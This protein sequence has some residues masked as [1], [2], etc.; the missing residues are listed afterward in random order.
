M[1]GYKRIIDT[2]SGNN[3][4]PVPTMLHSFMA[5]AEEKGLSQAQY[6]SSPKNI[7][8][9]HID[10]ALKYG[11]DG[12]L[13]DIDTCMEAGAIGIHVDLPEHEPARVTTGLSTNIDI[14][15]EAMDK[16]CLKK[17]DRIQIMLEAINNISN[18]TKGE[19]L[20][21]GNAD[22]GP[23]SLA[24]LSVGIT[25]FMMNLLDEDTIDKTKLLIDRAYDVH[26]E[27]HKM[28][29]DAGAD[30]TSFGDSSCGPDLI[31]REMYKEFSF[32]YHKRL[33]EDLN[34]ESIQTVCHICGN[35]DNI[36]EDVVEAGFPAIEVD[37]KTDIRRAQ[38]ILKGKSTMFGPI[39]PAGIFCFGSPTDVYNETKRILDIF[40][41]GGLVI[42]SGCALPPDVKQENIEAFTKAVRD[43]NLVR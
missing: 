38:K 36:L 39:D 21:R 18:E 26:L 14:C 19:L 13:I 37:Y 20:I 10:Y 22:Q 5:A 40:Q 2:I 7:A 1:S 4:K 34:K 17:Y 41:E 6:R 12:V 29:S 11:L 35:L 28:I 3:V 8:R 43:V 30:L 25:E 33:V 23:F 16:E 9:T 42:G 27:Y 24:M 15:I 31:S 32:P